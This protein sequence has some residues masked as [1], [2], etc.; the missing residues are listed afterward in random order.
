MNVKHK[1]LISKA[2]LEQWKAA[3]RAYI[4]HLNTCAEMQILPSD[5]GTFFAEW[6]ECEGK[7]E[8]EE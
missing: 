3:A 6:L 2:T 1:D 7:G 5:F 8:A 4:E